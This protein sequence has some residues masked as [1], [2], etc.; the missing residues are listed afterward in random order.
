MADACVFRLMC[1]L[2]WPRLIEGDVT[3]MDPT[4]TVRRAR[5]RGIGMA[6]MAMRT[7]SRPVLSAGHE[8]QGG[9]VHCRDNLITHTGLVRK[10][11]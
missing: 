11:C 8:V 9:M 5:S 10:V 3:C 7:W 2:N 1:L 6:C 4:W